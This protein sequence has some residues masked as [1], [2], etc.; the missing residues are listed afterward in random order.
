MKKFRLIRKN[1]K[2]DKYD[3]IKGK[4]AYYLGMGLSI[5]DACTLTKLSKDKINEFR[6]DPHFE[7][8]IQKCFS[9]NKMEYLE[10]IKGAA[11]S[12]Y[13]Q[14]SAW[15]LERKFPEEFGK[16][17]LV[18]HE[19]TLKLQ[20]FQKVIIQ[21]LSEEDPKIKHRILSKLRKF[22][23]SNEQ[24]GGHTFE[25]VALPSNTADDEEDL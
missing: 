15:Y 3:V 18:R 19:Y 13:W 7:A 20:T 9:K 24:I 10:A 1:G 8:F 14:A 16:R 21:V 6:A 23:F 5:D 11:S 25:P 4:L 22:D 12:G 2:S 17:D